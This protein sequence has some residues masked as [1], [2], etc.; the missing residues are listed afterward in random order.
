MFFEGEDSIE[1]KS[2]W[3]LFLQITGDL[4]QCTRIECTK[5]IKEGHAGRFANAYAQ[6]TKSLKKLFNNPIVKPNHHYALHIPQQLKLWGP[7]FGVA[8]FTGERLIG[9]LQKNPT[10]NQISKRILFCLM[11]DKGD[12]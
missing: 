1:I 9:I 2:N 8:E 11:D 4:V 5:A 6:Y 3:A 10:N 7:L 12:N